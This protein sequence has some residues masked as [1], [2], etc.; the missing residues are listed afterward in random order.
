MALP[1]FN[2]Y[3]ELFF[4]DGVK[5]V[6]SNS[7]KYLTNVSLAYWIMD[8][9]GFTGNGLKLYTNAYKSSDLKYLIEVLDYKFSSPSFG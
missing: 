3:Y 6:T 8:D 5:K 7:S 1:C 9:G 2:E 4:I